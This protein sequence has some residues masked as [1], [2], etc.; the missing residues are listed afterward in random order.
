MEILQSKSGQVTTL[1]VAGRLDANTSGPAQ[2]KIEEIID[3]GEKNLTV[4]LSRVE[5]ISSAGLRVFMMAAKRLK[6]GGGK[7]VLHSAPPQIRELFEIAGLSEIF[8]LCASRA[9]ALSRFG[10]P[11]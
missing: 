10:R 8:G 1:E 3:A 11:S 2:A 6:A 4:D 9:E 5:Y 7:I